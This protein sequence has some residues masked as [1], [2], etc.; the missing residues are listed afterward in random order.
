MQQQKTRKG[1][2]KFLPCQS[3]LLDKVCCFKAPGSYLKMLL[4]SLHNT[5]LVM[6][7]RAVTQVVIQ[8]VVKYAQTQQ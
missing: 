3:V 7:S 2:F 8:L 6:S 5:T 4:F 1:Y